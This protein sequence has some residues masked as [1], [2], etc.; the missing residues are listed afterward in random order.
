M[1]TLKTVTIEPIEDGDYRVEVCDPFTDEVI[2]A[3][4]TKNGDSQRHKIPGLMNWYLRVYH[5]DRLIYEENPFAIAPPRREPNM[6]L[7]VCMIGVSK[8][9]GK[10]NVFQFWNA[11]GALGLGRRTKKHYS[12]TCVLRM[13]GMGDL[14]AL[15]SGLRA[16][17]DMYPKEMLTLATLP[18][19][20]ILYKNAP[21]LDNC[22]PID[23]LE[24]AK[25]D[26]II[27]LR[28]QVEPPQIGAGKSTWEAYTSEDRSDLFDKILGVYPAQKRF[29]IYSDNECLD[30]M[31]KTMPE[32][33]VIGINSAMVA[34][35]RSIIPTYIDPLCRMIRE[36][37]EAKIVL[38]GV[39]SEW[40]AFLKDVN[41]EGVVNLIDKTTTEEM[42]ALCSLVGLLITPDT[43][44]LHIAGALGKRTLALFGNINPRTRISYYPNVRPIYPHGALSCIPCWD[45]HSCINDPQE[46]SRCMRLLNPD[47]IFNAIREE[48]SGNKL[49]RANYYYVSP[50]TKK[51]IENKTKEDMSENA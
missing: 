17:K 9:H 42:I 28:W 38:F 50:E 41:M 13:G 31:R 40:N 19:N 51:D 21:W 44:T 32:G 47:V 30:K 33:F 15:S 27:D 49:I 25:F 39:S 1:Q 34:P 29:Y 6:V 2:W 4:E 22:I 10:I 5:E 7:P 8:K 24:Y 45:V 48:M 23:N 36:Q 12:G 26:K 14:I 46:G 35:A 43:G 18:Q 16:Y 37:T 20:T 11:K 3:H